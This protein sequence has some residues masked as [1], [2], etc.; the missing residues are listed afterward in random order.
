MFSVQSKHVPCGFC[1]RLCHF[2]RLD[3]VVNVCIRPLDLHPQS[4]ISLFGQPRVPPMA[5]GSR[6]LLF[7]PL[8]GFAD[9]AELAPSVCTIERI[10]AFW[11]MAFSFA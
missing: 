9:V 2:S 10:G 1:F 4:L 5:F 7:P 8:V 3:G 6:T 11:R